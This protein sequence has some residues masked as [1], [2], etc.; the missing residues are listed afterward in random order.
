MCIG[1]VF[2]VDHDVVVRGRSLSGRLFELWVPGF[3]S[4]ILCF[5]DVFVG[6]A[7]FSTTYYWAQSSITTHTITPPYKKTPCRLAIRQKVQAQ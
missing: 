3:G 2:V 4:R 7:F 6:I 5:L 1:L